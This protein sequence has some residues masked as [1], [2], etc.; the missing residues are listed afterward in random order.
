MAAPNITQIASLVQSADWAGEGAVRVAV[1]VGSSTCQ[2][3]H[4]TL[5]GCCAVWE[6]ELGADKKS[7]PCCPSPQSYF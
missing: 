4:G 6:L 3:A 7:D 2:W 1:Q 5:A